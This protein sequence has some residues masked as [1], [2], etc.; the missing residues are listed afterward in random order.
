MESVDNI[1]KALG[2][3][4]WDL[5]RLL[6][7]KKKSLTKH[8]ALPSYDTKGGTKVAIDW[9]IELETQLQSL[10]DLGQANS[11]N[12]DLTSVIYSLDIFRIVAN[13]FEK[14]EG[15]TVLVAVQD[16]RG[17]LHLQALKDKI[18]E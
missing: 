12:E 15:K 6:N 7:Y 1:Y 5:T 17:R 16:E 9:Y 13:M 11:N 14:Q 8:G 2:K 10:L 3:A 4:F 18:S